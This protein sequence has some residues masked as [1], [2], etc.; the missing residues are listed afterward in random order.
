[1]RNIKEVMRKVKEVMRNVKEIMR[2]GILIKRNAYE[3][4]G[5]MSWELSY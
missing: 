5:G 2:E 4:M 1:M 3:M